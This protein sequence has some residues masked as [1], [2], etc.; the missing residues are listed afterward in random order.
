MAKFDK[1]LGAIL[2]KCNILTEEQKENLLGESERSN[3]SLTEAIVDKKICA[4]SDIISAISS[5]M[6][7]HPINLDK[8]K[9][10]PMALEK[11]SEEQCKSYQVLPIS[12]LGKILTVAVANPFDVLILDDVKIVTGCEIVPVISTDMALKRA[13]KNAFTEEVDTGEQMDQLLAG[14]ATG[15]MELKEDK[16]DD[17]LDLA[18]DLKSEGSPV[19]KLVNLLI[20]QAIESKASDIHI[21][22][23]ERKLRVR[24]RIDGA[25]Q[26][27]VSPP[28]KL[29]PAIVSR[30]KIMSNMDI[31]ERRK[32]QDG[33]YQMRVKGRQVDFRVSVLPMVHGEK[34]CIRILD[35]SGLSLSLESLGFETQALEDFKWAVKQPYGMLLVTGPTGSGKSTTLYS[36][37]REV[38]TVEDNI[39]TVED[40]V[41][42]QLDG[43]N[44]VPVSEKRGLTFAAALRS[45]LRQDPDTVMIGEIRDKE[46]A[47]IAVKAA[48][49][50]HL[51]LSTL[52]TNDAPSTI[53]RL[54][55]M[56]IDPFMV[57][58]SVIMVAAQRL[59][60]KLCLECREK[61]VP[62]RERVL[63]VGC[64][65]DEI[66]T[67]QYYKAK[68][69]GRCNA[70]YKG[71]FAILETMR[72]R[73]EIRRIVIGGG[74]A[75]D[76]RGKALEKDMIT[77]RRCAL[78]NALRGKTSIEEVLAMTQDE[79]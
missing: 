23:F 55:D 48:L 27:T 20:M 34:V 69:C 12:K 26:E 78:L 77:L 3:A 40:P 10:N 72:M 5:E 45:I 54:I 74:S 2:T 68:G 19:V 11:L 56:G 43:V 79:V 41:E 21:E 31:A 24:Y 76:I 67:G 30:I 65:E 9:P 39:T 63:E 18:E 61:Y 60:R 62:P 70:G 73:E 8:V 57:S 7:L 75:L 15:D 58:S 53:T 59:L 13:I 6:N 4:E 71:R 32:P 16:E 47:E 51:V 29:H 52:H 14:D 38:L 44:Q 46:T 28:K 35:S 50:G 42:Y 22:P 37:V 64:K 49:T 17:G 1:K 36:S 66:E 25:C 33:K